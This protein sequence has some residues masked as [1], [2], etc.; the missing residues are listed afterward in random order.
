[1]ILSHLLF[2]SL[3]LHTKYLYIILIF[4]K[5]TCFKI[6]RSFYLKNNTYNKKLF[7]LKQ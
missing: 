5:K 4:F 1:M 3:Q 2:S 7:M 6:T